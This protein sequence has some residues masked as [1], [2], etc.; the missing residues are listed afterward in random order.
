[1]SVNPCFM[2]VQIPLLEKRFS[3]SYYRDQ[4]CIEYFLE[5][6][7]RHEQISKNLILSWD[8][9]KQGLYVSKFYPELFRETASRYL[10]AACFYLMVH[11]AVHEF[12]LRDECPVWLETDTG[13]FRNFYA[14]LREFDFHVAYARV[15]EKVCL[16]GIYH[17]QPVSSCGIPQVSDPFDL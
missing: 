7:E 8:T 10:S 4:T 6:R 14:K 13:V 11:H 3:L 15:G 2:D 5:S 12:H 1:M 9:T 17:D 16:S